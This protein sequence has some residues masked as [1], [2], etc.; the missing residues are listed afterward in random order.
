M[1]RTFASLNNKKHPRLYWMA[2]L[3]VVSL[4]LHLG[5]GPAAA[6]TGDEPEATPAAGG[7]P[8]EQTSEQMQPVL[9]G[10][11]SGFNEIL[12]D[13]GV[14][15]YRK[16][17]SGGQPDFVQVISL[18]QGASVRLLHGTIASPG[19]GGGSYGGNN[20]SF[21]RQS[22]QTAWDGFKGST[23][24]AFC[25]A[26]G[27]FFST[28]NDPTPLAF[29]LKKDGTITSDGYGST[30]EYPGQLLMLELWSNR[31]DIR[32]LSKDNL[33][34]S[35]APNV[36]GGLSESA[37]KGVYTYTGRTFVGVDDADG[38]GTYET[39][40]I[41]VSKYSRQVDAAAVLRGFGADKV[42][43]LDG[44]NSTQLICKDTSYATST[45]TIPQT[46]ATVRGSTS[47][48]SCPTINNWKGEYWNNR[49]LS[50]NPV[51]CRDDGSVNFDWGNG[52]PGSGVPS[53]NFSARWTRSMNFNAGT[54]RFTV[55]ADDGVRLWLD[56]SLIID[57]WKDQG[58]TTY[59]TDR[60][61]SAGSHSLK[62]EYYE[63]GGGAVM[64]F[65]VQSLGV[66]CPT[67]NN[68][69]G[70]YWNNRTLSGNPVLCRDDGSVNF[71]W[72]NGSPG[73]GV[74]SDNF[75]ARWTRSMNFNAGTYRFTVR[76]DDGVRLWLDGSLI[77][78]Q[79][80]DQPPTT[81]TTDRTLSAGTHSLKIEYYEN[82]GGASIQFSVQQVGVTCPTI[83]AWKGE[84]WNNRTLN[85][86]P[87][88]CRNDSAVSFDWG[89]GSPG[90]GVPSDN[91]SARWT[92]TL[93]VDSGT[94]RFTV[95]ADD[96]V[97]LWVD[98]VLIIDQW[99]DQAPTTYSAS[100]SLS[101]GN[102]TLK[103]EFY[104]NA[105]G[106]V[107]QL[108]WE[109]TSTNVVISTNPAFDACR[110]PTLSEMQTWWNQSP[111]W[112]INL[113]IGGSSRGCNAWNQAN[114]TSQWVA[115]A[116]SQGWKFIPTWV[117]PQAPCSG[118]SS[119]LSYNLST[120]YSQGRAEADLAAAAAR[121]L[122]LTTNNGLG[123]TVI[124]YDMEGYPNE[125]GCRD[126]VK[127]FMAGWSSR[128]KELGTLSGGY[129]SSCASYLADWATI[130]NGN[131]PDAI[132]P[133]SWYAQPYVYK[134]TA[135]VWDV[136]C[137]SNGLWVNNQRIRQYAGGHNET[138]GSVTLNIDSNI[139]GGPVSRS[140]SSMLASDDDATSKVH[141]EIESRQVQEMGLVGAG[142]GWIMVENQLLWM[143]N[144]A[145]GWQHI[146]PALNSGETIRSAHFLNP[147]LGWV[148]VAGEPDA[149]NRSLFRLLNTR[150]G[151]RSWNQVS[152]VP[153][154]PIDGN[155]TQG[156]SWLQ[157]VSPTNGWVSFELASSSSF[158]QGSMLAT[159]DGGQ[160][161]LAYDLPAGG[162]VHFV[163]EQVGWMLNERFRDELFRTG[164]GGATWSQVHLAQDENQEY[165][166]LGMPVF[167]DRENGWLSLAQ[168]RE[169]GQEM[170]FYH[171]GDGGQT[172]MAYVQQSPLPPSEGSTDELSDSSQQEQE[173]PLAYKTL[174]WGMV[175]KYSGPESAWLL[176]QVNT[177]TGDKSSATRENIFRCTQRTVLLQTIDGGQTWTEL[178]P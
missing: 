139:A 55:R 96:G 94:Y 128:L 111:Y 81:Y 149:E 140:S 9:Q 105:G 45:R 51:L 118:Y 155:S 108:G 72:G 69:K 56:G 157:F 132:W 15:L 175:A 61:L 67:I 146:T 104:E 10:V 121:S 176:Q 113:Y 53:D 8:L 75:S 44:G 141:L 6:G 49:T 164:D 23:S 48:P 177:C 151:G 39:V 165:I 99:K 70:E 19:T 64:Q 143:E 59:T 24:G 87:V 102:H 172:W 90:S 147:K 42:M 114:L 124:Y 80:K 131:V 32:S 31:A 167:T 158:S 78:D 62:I 54:Y 85:G 47:S 79:W 28:N 1:N 34:G 5:A 119:R 107:M 86:N 169:E 22:L 91:F 98:G 150:D 36:L 109:R 17:Y 66:T 14:K 63:N 16:D 137:I 18:N 11:P 84:Y 82:G 46:I 138:W 103:V 156:R 166:F 88:L 168:V 40:L 76:A 26:N 126:A 74:P 129:G 33:Y 144:S 92:R 41:F 97:R 65:S 162:P 12:S 148:L 159:R 38:N 21:Y 58:P 112:E 125:S 3:L 120:A 57:Q 122:G 135:T 153:F 29:P 43:M 123:G 100:R 95:R 117:G 154:N 152:M 134:S 136:S 2:L 110:L 116:S 83:T 106:A 127:S 35:S 77:I 71:D 89:N 133:A 60:V 115:S 160:T 101:A 130:P 178:G 174:G 52:S 93:Y 20:P 73:S 13:T 30:S 142:Q 4:F 171:T 68:W 170:E 7:L 145:L 25:I 163:D 27:Q 50:G 37:D 173:E 161:W